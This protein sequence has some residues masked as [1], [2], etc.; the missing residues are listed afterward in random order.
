MHTLT[1]HPNSIKPSD[2]AQLQ[3]DREVYFISVG[4]TSK[5]QGQGP[6]WAIQTQGKHDELEQWSNLTYMFL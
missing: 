3:W 5:L 1:F 2:E 6:W 4:G